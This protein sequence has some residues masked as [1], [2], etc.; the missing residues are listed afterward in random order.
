MEI[1]IRSAESRG[2]TRAGW[3]SSRHSFAFGRY[4]DPDHVR[5]GPLRVL[6]DD[7]VQLGQG[8]GSHPHRD[9]EIVSYVLEGAMR[10][11]D[12][13][14]H[15]GVIQ[16]GEVQ[17]MRAGTGIVHSEVNASDNDRLRFLQIWLEPHTHGLEPGYAKVAPKLGGSE[18]VPLVSAT[19]PGQQV[20]PL[21]AAD[22][23]P[24]PVASDASIR[25]ARPPEGAELLH[26]L[27]AG[28]RGYLFVVEGEVTVQ[29]SR[30]GRRDAAYL[31]PVQDDVDVV[32]QGQAPSHVL[33]FDLGP[34]PR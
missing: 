27:E 12:S 8:F 21:D 6:N 16:T 5:W 14:G 13:S 1:R 25:A 15:E 10:H 29:G 9:M 32:V 22:G 2:T 26:R 28:R 17:V 18:W 33:L 11:E 7:R 19:T 30:L 34:P 3:L 4:R 31:G 24:V 20:P 23:P